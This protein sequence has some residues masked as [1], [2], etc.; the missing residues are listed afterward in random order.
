MLPKETPEYLGLDI[1]STI[2]TASEVGGD[3]FDYFP[4]KDEQSLYVVVGDATGHGMTAGMMVSITKA[5]LYGI[6]PIPPN[7]IL[8]RLNRV[9]KNIDLGLNRMAV[10]IAKFHQDKVELTSAAMPPIY[11][12]NGATKEVNEILIEGL[13]LGSFMDEN[14]DLLEISFKKQ[15]SL[16]F[17]SD[18]LPEATN[19]E[20]ELIGYDP[21]YNCIKQ[22]GH[23]SASEQKKALLDLG[24]S[25]L[26]DIQNQDDITIVVV[27]KG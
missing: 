6:P 9:I 14:F 11:H 16:I 18:G 13:P 24:S 22:N 20:G 23:L 17:I 21:V 26:G 7:K 1:S 10:N 2:K 12:Y 15:D 19:S 4:Q 8:K 3:Y 5:G 25:W 27:K